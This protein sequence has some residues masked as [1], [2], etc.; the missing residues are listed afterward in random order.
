MLI[1]IKKLFYYSIITFAIIVIVVFFIY[2]NSICTYN[3]EYYKVHSSLQYVSLRKF[4]YPYKAAISISSDVDR[5]ETLDEYMNISNYLNTNQM[6]SMGKGLGLEIGGSFFFWEPKDQ[7][8]SYFMGQ[9]EVTHAIIEQIKSG[10]ID[11]L[12]SYGKKPDF[13]REDAIAAITELK[14]NNLK[15]DV[16]IDHERSVSN[17]G[18]DVTFGY[19]DHLDSDAYHADVTIR[20]GIRY[21]WLGRVTMIVG[22]SVPITPKNFTSIYDPKY[23]IESAM[24]VSKEFMKNLLANLGIR[25]YYVQKYNDLVTVKNLDDSQKVYE[26]VRFDNYWMGVGT[27]AN[28][29]RLSYVISKKTLDRLKDIEGY[30]IVYTHFGVKT[31]NSLYIP[32]G[33]QSALVNLANE[34]RMGNIYVTTTSKLLN[35]HVMHKYMNWKYKEIENYI[36]LY[37]SDIKDPVIGTYVPKVQQLKGFTFYVPEG[38]G[39]R[40]FIGENEIKNVRINPKDHNGMSSVTIIN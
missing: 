3:R 38:K 7:S 10:Y 8:I 21:V 20:Y 33:T 4:P 12:H 31:D 29:N 2:I 27:G 28:A 15:I 39:I 23:P 25:K 32:T 16:W 9:P 35:Y 22:Q 18:D 30:M 11:I 13:K 1:K 14:N 40:I 34:Y 17:M 6:T 24:N 36:Y 26:F 19:G 5:N 37:I